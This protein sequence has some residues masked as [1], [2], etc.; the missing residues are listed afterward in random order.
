MR[1]T[2]SLSALLVA[3]LFS[4]A[5]AVTHAQ[6][7]LPPHATLYASGFEGPRGLAFGPDGTLYVAEAGLGGTASTVGQCQQVPAPLG[8]YHGGLTARISKVDKS[9]ARTTLVAGLPSTVDNQASTVGVTGLA[10]GNGEL[11]ALVGGGGCSHGNPG[12]P[13][14]ILQVDPGSG[15]YIQAANLSEFIAAHPGQNPSA[16]DYEPDGSW[17]DL[18][19]SNGRLLAIEANH[20]EIVSIGPGGQT[21]LLADISASDGHI[22]PTSIAAFDD[23]LYVG[24]LGIAPFAPQSAQVLTVSRES[25]LYDPLPGFTL[26]NFGFGQ[27]RVAGSKAGFTTITG[28]AIGPD[29]LLYVLELATGG[30]IT[31][32]TGKVVRVNRAGAIEDVV[33]GLFLPTGMTFGPDNALYVSNFGAAPGA[34]GQVLRISVILAK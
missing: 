4:A 6:A 33:T 24:S 29:G 14:S 32:K 3:A 16:A 27:Y 8:P 26:P 17:Y 1:K 25:L 13:N 31:P 22:V 20:G 5:P 9:G 30:G 11:Y 21:S 2:L 12:F 7:P 18:I 15:R 28:M 10:F 19:A 34:A 23:N